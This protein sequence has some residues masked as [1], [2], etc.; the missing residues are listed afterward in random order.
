MKVV[1]TKMRSESHGYK[2]ANR[3]SRLQGRQIK[4]MVTKIPS[5]RRGY[6]K[7][8]QNAWLQRPSKGVVTKS[9]AK[10]VVTQRPSEMCGYIN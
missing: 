6:K 2:D 8:K 10:G 3:K 4:V 5:E 7:A 9:P 1:V